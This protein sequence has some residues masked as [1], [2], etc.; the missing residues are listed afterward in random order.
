[1]DITAEGD[2]RLQDN[3][4]GQ[5]VGLDAPATVSGSYT[6]TLPAAI[7]AVD[8]TLTINNTDGTLQWATPSSFNP[9]AAV[10]FNESGADV[11]FRVESEDDEYAFIVNG[12]TNNVGV[13]EADPGHKFT[14]SGTNGAQ[15]SLA[16]FDTSAERIANLQSGGSAHADRRGNLQIW[17]TN[18]G[19]NDSIA[20]GSTGT[21]NCGLLFATRHADGIAKTAMFIEGNGE[22]GIGVTDP[23]CP[24]HIGFDDSLL[25]NLEAFRNTGDIKMNFYGGNS[26]SATSRTKYGTYACEI[27]TNTDGSEA[28]SFTWDL[29]SS[30]SITERM[31]LDHSGNLTA[32]GTK[33]F[34]IDHP[35]ASMTST[36][37]L[38]FYATEGP[39]AD[40]LFRGSVDLIAG[41]A[42]VD[43]DAVSLQTDG[44][45]DA[46]TR[47][48][49]IWVNNA[50]GWSAVKGSISGNA[51]TITCQDETST[52]TVH[53]L[54]VADRYDNHMQ[55]NMTTDP[56]TGRPLVEY[57]KPDPEPEP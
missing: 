10:T 57:E 13:G 29:K 23:E 5:Y 41:S 6:L 54:I 22:V 55:T 17:G 46:L 32:D 4:G 35:L 38:V 14:V 49:Q 25:L 24:L 19:Q 7:G 11:D 39:R 8:Q 42:T 52:D 40:C 21:A 53:W 31:E 34:R 12:G 36:H 50:T 3:T 16:G 37:K 30:G 27:T 18:A 1:V 45:F 28:S 56:T 48:P 51:L 33:S 47:D 15:G 20:I 2:L 43:I 44:T 26:A 9:D